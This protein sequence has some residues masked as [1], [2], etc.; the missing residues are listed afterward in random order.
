MTVSNYVAVCKENKT[1]YLKE[2]HVHTSTTCILDSLASLSLWLT[3]RGLRGP[4]WP[5][6]RHYSGTPFRDSRHG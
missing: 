2:R 5:V 1:V 3:G 4:S 6:T